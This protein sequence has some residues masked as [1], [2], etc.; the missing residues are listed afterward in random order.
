MRCNNKHILK[1]SSDGE[2]LIE[3]LFSYT[4]DEIKGDN[5]KN[6]EQKIGN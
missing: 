6:I 4:D 3:E 5:H 1:G 2:K